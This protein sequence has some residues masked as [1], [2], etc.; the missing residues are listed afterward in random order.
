MKN[1]FTFLTYCG[2]HIVTGKG[3]NILIDPFLDENPAIN[4]K[5][6]DFKKIDLIIVS[7]GAY[8]HVGDTAALAKRHDCWVICSDDVKLLMLE[9]GVLEKHLYAV[10]WGMTIALNGI[11]IKPVECHHRSNVTLADGRVVSTQPL[12]FIITLEDGTRIYNAGDTALF[13][14]MK[15]Q[16]ELYRPHI[17]L[18]NAVTDQAEDEPELGKPRVIMGEMSPYEAALATQWL[19]VEVAVPCHHRVLSNPQLQEY[20]AIMERM[21]MDTGCLTKV[22][23]L[24]PGDSFE[25]S[26]EEQ[27]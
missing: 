12:A 15:L 25:Y 5:S 20:I 26:A 1:K 8:D 14:D 2:F 9:S 4:I 7:H 24:G 16:G 21:R 19:G 13:S 6:G 3:Y 17:G 27:V 18:I 11:Q 22:I 10:P 23:A